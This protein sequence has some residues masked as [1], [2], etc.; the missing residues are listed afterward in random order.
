MVFLRITWKQVPAVREYRR[1]RIAEE[2]SAKDR[3]KSCAKRIVAM[4]ISAPMRPAVKEEKMGSRY[5]KEIE[6]L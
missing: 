5:G 3:R 6:G 1:P 2:K 4:G